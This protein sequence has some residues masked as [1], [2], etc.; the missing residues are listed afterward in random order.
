MS[1]VTIGV[2]NGVRANFPMR[3]AEAWNGAGGKLAL[4]PFITPVVTL[5]I[6]RWRPVVEPGDTERYAREL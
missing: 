2:M 6:A 5:D 3:K 4:T 1:S